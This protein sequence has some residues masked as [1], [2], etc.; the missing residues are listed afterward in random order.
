MKSLKLKLHSTVGIGPNMLLAKL[1]MDLDAKNTK[2]GIAKWTYD[3]I[4]D[5]LW[6]ITPLSKMWELA[7]NGISS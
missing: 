3:D 5:K 1:S 2:L 6:P 4:K 7:V